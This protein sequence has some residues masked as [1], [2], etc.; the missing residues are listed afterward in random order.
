M[1]SLVSFLQDGSSSTANKSAAAANEI[2]LNAVD[3]I[4][5]L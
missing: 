2:P 5:A 1:P 4:T 3:T